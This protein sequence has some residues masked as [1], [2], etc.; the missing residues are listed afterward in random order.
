MVVSQYRRAFATAFARR[1]NLGNKIKKRKSI[2]H[3]NVEYPSI[4]IGIDDSVGSQSFIGRLVSKD[5]TGFSVFGTVS[6]AGIQG[7]RIYIVIFVQ[8][9]AY[10][11][12]YIFEIV[13]DKIP[14][15]IEQRA[16]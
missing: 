9:L 2:A 7:T 1:T 16:G 6:M 4:Y 12:V 11:I 15:L 10:F 8:V 13:V 5:I 14:D 3:C